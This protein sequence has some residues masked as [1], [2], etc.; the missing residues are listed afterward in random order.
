[1][2]QKWLVV[3]MMLCVMLVASPLTISAESSRGRDN[4]KEVFP[5]DDLLSLEEIR[6][7]VA[8]LGFK[9][10]IFWITLIHDGLD[11]EDMTANMQLE[12]ARLEAGKFYTVELSII[13]LWD[14]QT[15]Q[16][17]T[18]TFMQARFPQTVFANSPN[19][20]G[21]A[22]FGENVSCV[23]QTLPATSGEDLRIHYVQNS[24][25]VL[26]LGAEDFV[27]IDAEA[28]LESDSG[29]CLQPFLSNGKYED[30]PMGVMFITY[31][32]YT[33]PLKDA[34]ANENQMNFCALQ[35]VRDEDYTPAPATTVSLVDKKGHAIKERD[36]LS[37]AVTVMIVIAV[38]II[39]CGVVA[40]ILIV[41]GR[42]KA[43]KNPK[44]YWG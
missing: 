3:L 16:A 19:A 21:A 30:M 29:L 23:A 13:T 42:H 34:D 39:C 28:L 7:G 33:E 11:T 43:K 38:I 1:M 40:T 27:K 9:D 22:T 18:Q 15:R 35:E 4:R 12:E 20:F 31:S 6:D 10:G 8:E 2:K 44:K 25:R 41:Y 5:F 37:D 17:N 32:I 14:D 36:Q 24:A 26:S